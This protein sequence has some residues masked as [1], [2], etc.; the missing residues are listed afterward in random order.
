MEFLEKKMIMAAVKID[1]A[2]DSC[3]RKFAEKMNEKTAEGYMDT[4]IKI[5]IA[6]VLGVALLAALKT[7]IID[8]FFPEL[9]DQIMD[10]FTGGTGGSGGSGGGTGGGAT[11]TT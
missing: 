6:V 1:C 2:I 3:R 7:F 11:T 4:L 9:E 8:K 5:L 10:M